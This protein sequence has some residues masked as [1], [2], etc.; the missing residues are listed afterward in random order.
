M[1]SI[2]KELEDAHLI[3]ITGHLRP[4][5][6]C[7]G[8]SLGL[9]NYM[10]ANMPDKEVDIYL[11]PAEDCFSFLKNFHKIKHNNSENKQ[12]DVFI[13]LDCGDLERVA[14][15]VRDYVKNAKKT[16]CI[17]HHLTNL[18]FGD[19]NH[20]MP[21]ISSASEVLYELLDEKLVTKD[22]AE[23]LYTGMV[24]DTGVFKY[25]STTSRTMAIAGKLMDT[26]IDFTSIIDDTFFRKSYE[27]NLLMGEAVASSVLLLDG[28]MIYSYISQEMLNKYGLTGRDTGGIIDQLRFTQGVEVAVFMYEL[29]ENKTKTS[30]R[31]V[32][33]VDVNA[34]ANEFGGGGHIRAAGFTSELSYKEIVDR[35]EELIE[36]VI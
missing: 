27:Q 21:H 28:K 11:E 16:I 29:P 3:G 26:G 13:V 7:V 33:Y 10:L 36:K 9:Y 12:Y 24:H 35:L 4:D 20:V 30:L 34:I 22:V 1:E 32:K 14:V 23:C 5:G 31:S 8:S 17:D 15:F 19:V 2:K 6:D 25:Q 18:Q